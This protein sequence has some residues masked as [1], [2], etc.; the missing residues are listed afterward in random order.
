VVDPFP[1]EAALAAG[2]AL[3]Q[4]LILR[5]AARPVSHGVAVLA[6]D[7]RQGTA[8]CVKCR[9]AQRLFGA[10]TDRFDLRVVGVHAAVDV[11]IGAG[12]I[13]LVMQ[14][15]GWIAKPGPLSHRCQVPSAAALVAQRPHDDAGMVL[16][17]LDHPAH[18]VHERVFPSRVVGGVAPPP[19]PFESVGL[20]V[21]L[22]DNVEAEFVAQV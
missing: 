22:V 7:E 5:E 21:T 20:Q 8:A 16:V 15:P 1:H 6:Q 10:L 2:V 11:D 18:P 17:A 4:F 13:A 9:I 3:E 14:R 12:L 19:D